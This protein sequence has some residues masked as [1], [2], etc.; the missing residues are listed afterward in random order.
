MGNEKKKKLN[1]SKRCVRIAVIAAAVVL[2]TVASIVC[3]SLYR[4]YV[5]YPRFDKALARAVEPKLDLGTKFDVEDMLRKGSVKLV[6]NE[7]QGVDRLSVELNYGRGGASIKADADGDELEAI[8]TREAI[9]LAADGVNSGLYWGV[10]FEYVTDKI[11][12]S[13]LNPENKSE[14]SLA[15]DKYE[16][17]RTLIFQ[18]E[19]IAA[20]KGEY[21]EDAKII[22][23]ALSTAH[24]QSPLYTE[25][26][27]YGAMTVSGVSRRA[28]GVVYSFDHGSLMGYLDALSGLFAEPTDEL[29][30]ATERIICSGILKYEIERLVGKELC[31]CEDVAKTLDSL[32]H[33]IDVFLG[34]SSWSGRLTV[35]YAGRA[36]SAI[37]LSIDMKKMD[38]YALADFGADPT[39][40]KNM[41]FVFDKDVFDKDG[42]FI[43]SKE[44][45]L[46]YDAQKQGRETSVEISRTV[47]A[48]ESDGTLD[49]ESYVLSAILDRKDDNA[50][51]TLDKS[52][53]YHHPWSLDL[54]GSTTE[55][56]F[57]KS[58]ELEERASSV[59]LLA[60]DGTMLELSRRAKK[61]KMPIAEDILTVRVE[62]VDARFDE[63]CEKYKWLI[64]Y[65]KKSR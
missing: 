54:D 50:H 52:V 44:Q 27:S 59:T 11:D 57:D 36:L 60:E 25:E 33:L 22:L 2:L 1:S 28:R 42:N 29:R 3:V 6:T 55:Q 20:C 16:E 35:A 24:E 30:T 21:A 31:E 45:V 10:G 47:C 14:Y 61:V 39:K 49:K 62:D 7:L 65:I 12:D 63:F 40:D 38:I 17:L 8:L 9:A 51:V 15:A 43:R 37:E 5:L 23:E 19:D 26:R 13:F 53:E 4:N 34:S 56:L 32:A 18:L 41:R 48:E 58:F 64:E 46:E